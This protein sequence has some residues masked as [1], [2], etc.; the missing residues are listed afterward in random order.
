MAMLREYLLAVRTIHGENVHS[1]APGAT[2]YIDTFT[3]PLLESRS[4][5]AGVSATESS[6]AGYACADQYVDFRGDRRNFP[7]ALLHGFSSPEDILEVLDRCL[8]REDCASKLE[9]LAQNERLGA[10]KTNSGT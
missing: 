8:P 1:L 6:R 5:P 10:L 2:D 4:I 9:R 7:I 3:T